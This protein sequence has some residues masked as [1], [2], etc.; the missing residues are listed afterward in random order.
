MRC[1][2]ELRLVDVYKAK[3]STKSV[4]ATYSL[5]RYTVTRAFFCKCGPLKTWC[6]PFLGYLPACPPSLQHR[7]YKFRLL[8]MTGYAPRTYYP[9]STFQ[10]ILPQ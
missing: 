6:S 2:Y 7:N 9:H 5:P 3:I 1:T 4:L 8:S 10:G